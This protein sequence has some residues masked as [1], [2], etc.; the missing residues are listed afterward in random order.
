MHAVAETAVS[1]TAG[2][3]HAPPGEVP[4]TDEDFS[5]IVAMVREA[6]GISLSA[7]KRDLVYGRL[8]RR[9]RALRLDSFA[10]YRAVLD[11]EDG[12]AE[13]VRMIN[14]ITTNLTS[15]FR[16][17][18]HF[19]TL[20]RDVLPAVS[21]RRLRI[22]SAGCSSGE[23]PYSIAMTLIDAVPDLAERDARILA[24]DIDTDMVAAASAGRYGMEKLRGISPAMRQAHTRR[25]DAQTVEM[26][27][28]LKS[29]ITFKPLNLLAPWPM[30]GPF[31]AIF[32]RN[33][34][35][36]F[37]KP[38]QRVLFDRF[39]EMLRPDGHLFVGHSESLYRVSDRFTH[40][41]RTVYRRVR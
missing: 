20:A 8:R 26:S 25:I 2:A 38:T 1:A 40:I 10:R 11:G 23:E 31:D 35:I 12:A 29:L 21:G 28:G 39:A 13:R 34:V 4:L 17:P 9:L 37:D 30:R 32:C 18:H 33:V 6:S 22:W 16:E 5:A 15:F 27:V 24:T 7:S 14:A 36:Y 41:G 3:A 19:E